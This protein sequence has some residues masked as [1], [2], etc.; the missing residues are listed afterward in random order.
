MQATGSGAER[1][2]GMFGVFCVAVVFHKS[3]SSPNCGSHRVI[4]INENHNTSTWAK[5]FF[6]IRFT[7]V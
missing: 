4:R 5:L 3:L 1:S 6:N 7:M 2:I